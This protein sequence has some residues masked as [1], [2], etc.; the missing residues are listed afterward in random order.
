MSCYKDGDVFSQRSF[1][2]TQTSRVSGRRVSAVRSV[3]SVVCVCVCVFFFFFFANLFRYTL[4][5][6]Q[7]DVTAAL[8]QRVVGGSLLIRRHSLS[9][10]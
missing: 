1:A 10:Y 6:R 5:A 4:C 7:H 8:F 9:C 3:K 2:T